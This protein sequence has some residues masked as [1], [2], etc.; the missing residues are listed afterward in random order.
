MTPRARSPVMTLHPLQ[1]YSPAWA[2][3]DLDALR[4]S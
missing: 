4:T 1:R 2:D 3:G